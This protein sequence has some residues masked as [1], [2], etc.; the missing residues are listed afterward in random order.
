MCE[1]RPSGDAKSASEKLS[2]PDI[3]SRL[4]SRE[5]LSPG[6]GQPST[7]P[8]CEFTPPQSN[9]LDYLVGPG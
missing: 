5:L 6:L 7:A 8:T 9:S 4:R 2:I 1:Q 3:P